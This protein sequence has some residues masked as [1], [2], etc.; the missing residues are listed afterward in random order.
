[1]GRMDGKTAVVTG[2]ASGIGRA[3]ARLLAAEGARV[4]IADLQDE[5]GQSLAQELGPE[6][7][8]FHAD[9]SREE[10]MSA[11]VDHACERFGWLDCM[12]N[13]AGVAGVTAPID[14]IPVEGFDR[15]LAVNLRGVF[16]GMK[17][18]VRVMRPRRSGCIISIASIAGLETGHADHLYSAAKAAVIHLTRSVAAEVGE[19]GIRV[20]CICPGWIATPILGKSVGLS[21][22]EA[23]A[24]LERVREVLQG[25]QPI[26]R[27]GLPEDVARAALY[28]ASD[29]AGFVSGHALVVDGGLS[30]GRSWSQFFLETAPLA[31]ALGLG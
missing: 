19:E 21:Q 22:A 12:I 14:Q 15:T 20:N 13:N 16:L 10:E 17:H 26:K 11:L 3:I 31:Q 23:E 24:T 30:G 18:A 5:L 28:L 4:V 29:E 8:Y 6:A 7:S 2:G 9:V 1:M 25:F 27:P